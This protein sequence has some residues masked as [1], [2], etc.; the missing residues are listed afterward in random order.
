MNKI[1]LFILI[2]ILMIIYYNIYNLCEPFT[3]DNPIESIKKFTKEISVYRPVGSKQLKDVK[4]KILNKMNQMNLKSSEQSFSRNIKNKKYDFSNLIGIN[5]NAKAPYILLGAHLDSP[6][7]DGCESTIDACTSISIILELVKNILDKNPNFP[8]MILFVD[9]EE[10]IDGP[11]EHENTLSGSRYF[12]DNFDLKL[13]DKVYI[14]DLIGGDIEN[15]KIAGFNNNPSTFNDIKKLYSIN[16]KYK[17]NIF[18]NPDTFISTN[19]I[20]DDHVPF[21]EK[22]KYSLNLIPYTFPKNHHKLDDNYNN[23]NWD[24]VEVFYNIFYEF[25]NN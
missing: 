15:N 14:F 10:A 4:I 3:I 23:V 17:Y 9:G 6:Q 7:I 18:M 16:L 22:D 24:Y 13:I 1:K 25:I 8:I 11:W 5:P 19:G 12:V 21:K 2:L 20:I